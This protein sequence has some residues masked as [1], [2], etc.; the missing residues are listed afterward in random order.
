MLWELDPLH[1]PHKHH[2]SM[3]WTAADKMLELHSA[4]GDQ[5][6]LAVPCYHWNLLAAGVSAVLH[7]R[8][9]L[10]LCQAGV[11][12]LTLLWEHPGPLHGQ[13][14]HAKQKEGIKP[15]KLLLK[16]SLDRRLGKCQE[17][18]LEKTKT[19][20]CSEDKEGGE[21]SLW[22]VEALVLSCPASP[23]LSAVCEPAFLN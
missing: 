3:S 19:F 4:A 10:W 17:H 2:F 5:G 9:P 18:F 1:L 6:G 15:R 13:N 23:A 22:A 7:L 12:P 8:T 14:R 21:F 11:K 16:L 20:N